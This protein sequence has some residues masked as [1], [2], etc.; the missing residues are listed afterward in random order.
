MET[1]SVVYLQYTQLSLKDNLGKSQKIFIYY[2]L[3]KY[4]LEST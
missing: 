1:H 3:V 2:R 4:E